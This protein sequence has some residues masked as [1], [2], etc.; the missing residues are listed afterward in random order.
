MKTPDTLVLLYELGHVEALLDFWRAHPEERVRT[1]VVPFDPTI[2]V[3]L[4]KHSVEFVSGR[5]YLPQDTSRFM[6]AEEWSAALLEG[7]AWEWF[8]Y[9]GVTLAPVFFLSLQLYI[10]ELLY[11]GVGIGRTLA[12]HPELKR[13]KT[14]AS[15]QGMPLRGKP[16]VRK[17]IGAVVACAQAVAAQRG[18]AT[19][20][21]GEW[22]LDSSTEPFVQRLQRMVLELAIRTVNALVGALRP[23]GRVR[24]LASDYWRS[25]GPIMARLPQGELM[26]YDRGEALQARFTNIWRYRMRFYNAES[27]SIR[28]RRSERAGA[29]QAFTK[30]WEQVRGQLP[31]FLHDGFAANDLIAGAIDE[32][33]TDLTPGALE[34]VDGVYALIERLKPQVVFVR[35][36][37][38]AQ[39]HFVV[40]P[41]VA[42]ALGI[43]SLELQHGIE[44]VGPG[45]S[46]RRVAEYI[47]VYGQRMQDSLLTYS[48]HS[49]EQLPIV[50]SPRFDQYLAARTNTPRRRDSRLEVVCTTSNPDTPWAGYDRY[51][52]EQYFVSIAKAVG[53]VPG[54]HV[55]IKLRSGQ[56][57][58]P[59]YGEVIAKAFASVPHTIAE[60][61]SLED[62]FASA[63][64]VI[65]YYST[66]VLEAMLCRKPVI[67]FSMQAIEQEI[68]RASLEPYAA[69]GGLLTAYTEGE[70]AAAFK[71]LAGDESLRAE[72]S[73]HAEGVLA[74]FNLF[75]GKASQHIVE[76][77]ERLSKKQTP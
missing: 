13:L 49:R 51:D 7:K 26:L 69:A 22:L 40:L 63:D 58:D 50:G 38:G 8:T 73:E 35:T 72:L 59:W 3:A 29:H 31:R 33:I 14:F 41:L 67:V 10:T 37:M 45:F 43:P 11:Y 25:V 32:I 60:H 9:R 71:K 55:T 70:L 54:A 46:S 4:A 2:E 57:R 27:F 18:I 16:L 47:A 76:L 17:Q 34:L 12:A 44:Y 21:L 56:S 48:H 68:I 5:R 61:E 64:I 39:A 20:V 62:L 6:L 75:D 53:Q 1:L 36:S 74:Q 24:V 52:M 77:V 66:A 28:L 15:L 42:R 19:E 30:Q 23:P 65:S